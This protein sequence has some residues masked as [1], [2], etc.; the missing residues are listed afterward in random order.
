MRR[1]RDGRKHI[2]WL[3][4]RLKL[5]IITKHSAQIKV[6]DILKL[7]TGVEFHRNG[8]VP[9][10]VV[11]LGDILNV[12]WSL[13][14]KAIKERNGWNVTDLGVTTY[15]PCPPAHKCTHKPNFDQ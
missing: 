8:G 10:K 11:Q 15:K 7:V 14:H 5:D 13:G 9:L 6:R 3:N 4:N 2:T 1:A 12:I